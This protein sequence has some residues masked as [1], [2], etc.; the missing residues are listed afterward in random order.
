M[1]SIDKPESCAKCSGK[2]LKQDTSTF[3]TW[4]SSGQWPF[5]TLGYPNGEDYK[6]YYPTDMM[7]MGRDILFFWAARMIMLSLYRTRKIPFKNLYL[8]GLIRDKNGYKMSKSRGNGINPVAMIKKFGADA[9]RL[10]LVMNV[11]PGQDSSLYEEKIESFRNFITKLW[12]I[13]RYAIQSVED[14]TLVDTIS[15]KDILTLSE[16]WIIS[17]LEDTVKTVTDLM[18]KKN[19]SLAQERLRKFTWDDFADWYI[20]I[21]KFEKNP[22]VLGYVLNKILKMWHPFTPFV[23]EKIYSLVKREKDLLMVNKWPKGEKKLMSLKSKED[24]EDLKMMVI[25]I[26][27]MRANYHIKPHDIIT[28]FSEKSDEKE[29]IE[30]LAKVKFIEMKDVQTKLISIKTRKR[31]IGLDISHLIDVEKEKEIIIKE[32]NN[33]EAVIVK[34]QKMLSNQKFTDGAA[35]EIIDSHKRKLNEYQEKLFVQQG[36]LKNLDHS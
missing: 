28:A 27:N 9:L 1:I 5:S 3:D 29:L 30:K 16:K 25:R 19:I 22:Q 2:N 21:N 36:L 32:I 17:E 18:K 12:N 10:S 15:K 26:R 7:I 23:T 8:T 24:F 13:S 6:K 34:N 33:L 4:F 35:K 20:E 14:F 31:S 11:S